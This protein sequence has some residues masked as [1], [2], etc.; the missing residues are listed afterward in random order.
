[1]LTMCLLCADWELFPQSVNWFGICTAA[2]HNYV[3]KFWFGSH[4]HRGWTSGKRFFCSGPGI[5]SRPSSTPPPPGWVLTVWVA[6]KQNRKRFKKTS[7]RGRVVSPLPLPPV[8]RSLNNAEKVFMCSWTDVRPQL[9]LAGNIFFKRFT[10][11]CELLWQPIEANIWDDLMVFAFCA[12][13]QKLPQYGVSIKNRI[14]SPE[15]VREIGI[16]YAQG[17]ERPLVTFIK[18]IP[19][20]SEGLPLNKQVL[21]ETP[22]LQKSIT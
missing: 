9:R 7:E 12:S 19:K 3:V 11:P 4:L 2:V 15:G 17:T 13:F 14:V 16:S 20:H 6:P 22:N 8:S 5:C 21:R 10:S 18:N 1:M